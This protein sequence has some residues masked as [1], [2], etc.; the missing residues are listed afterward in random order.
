MAPSRSPLSRQSIAA[1]MTE[2][3]GRSAVETD[4]EQLKQASVD[5]FKKYTAVNGIFDGPI[6]AAIVYP[7]RPRTSRPCCGSP[8]TTWSTSYPAPEAPPPRAGWRP[9]SRTRSWSTARG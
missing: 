8:R 3:L 5:R 9:S 7:P 4:E 1:A 6:P 2:L